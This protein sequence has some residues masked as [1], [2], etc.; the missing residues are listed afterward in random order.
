MY[1]GDGAHLFPVRKREIIGTDG[2]SK[3]DLHSPFKY[4]RT[5]LYVRRCSFENR[6]VV[7]CEVEMETGNEEYVVCYDSIA[8]NGNELGPDAPNKLAFH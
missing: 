8:A 7:R 1:W 2:R 4:F 5:T 6:L 3:D